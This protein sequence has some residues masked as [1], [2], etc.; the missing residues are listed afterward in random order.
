MKHPKLLLWLT[1]ASLAGSI[2][3]ARSDTVTASWVNPV[4]NNNGSAIPAT[5]AGSLAS[6][7]LE[8]GTC[9]GTAFGTKAGEV[10]RAMPVTT[11]T[12]NLDPGTTCIRVKVTNTF[13]LESAA[14]NVA[15]K[16]VSPPTPGAPTNLTVTEPVAY[17]IRPNE[18]TFAF[19]RGRAV[20]TARLGAACDEDR[21]TGQG[22][23]AL[24][25]PSRVKLTRE[26]RS[27]AL[28]AKCAGAT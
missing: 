25:R 21:T 17:D 7:R 18:T 9:V 6:A 13:G 14:S 11:V 1:I 5:G 22:F 24:E 15:V 19:D 23:Y 10:V 12:L 27:T 26:P 8:Y 16:V 2:D 20:G 28:V 4:L 3:Y